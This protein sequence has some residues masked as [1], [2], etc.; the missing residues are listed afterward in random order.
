MK[1]YAAFIYSLVLIS[2]FACGNADKRGASNEDT[3]VEEGV[4][5][6]PLEIH[7]VMKLDENGAESPALTIDISLSTIK[8][9]EKEAKM[10][11]MYSQQENLQTLL[12]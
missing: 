5:I 2:F 12:K 7:E 9:K 8:A 3:A 11:I 4:E 6:T 1:K 10:L